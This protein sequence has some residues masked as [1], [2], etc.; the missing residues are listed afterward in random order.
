MVVG[1]LQQSRRHV[2]AMD[3]DYLETMAIAQVTQLTREIH[4]RCKKKKYKDLTPVNRR[5]FVV[6]WL[7][8][9]D[10]DVNSQDTST[11]VAGAVWV[12]AKR[13]R[14][15]RSLSSAAFLAVA[16]ICATVTC[17]ENV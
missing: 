10:Q 13:L 11:T 7:N 15:W 3:Q 1:V 9:D 6:T 2:V 4:I 8:L 16:L 5:G 14:L 12:S 17:R